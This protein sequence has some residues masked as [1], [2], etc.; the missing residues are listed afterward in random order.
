[1][2]RR[3]LPCLIAVAALILAGCSTV[4]PDPVKL[5]TITVSY[6]N[7][8]ANGGVVGVV[9]ATPA[10]SSKEG[11]P[12]DSQPNATVKTTIDTS[13]GASAA[14][15]ETK[16][17]IKSGGEITGLILSADARERYNNLLSRYGKEV[18]GREYPADYGLAAR[19]DGTWQATREAAE[20]F[21]VMNQ[22]WRMDGCPTK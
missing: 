5:D 1:M 8:V 19:S 14:T 20:M 17:S 15:Q 18:Y 6:D 3:V 16:A 13:A 12:V 21:D 11:K 7:G 2:T 22:I 4:T 9:T 10:E